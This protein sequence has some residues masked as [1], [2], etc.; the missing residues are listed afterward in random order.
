MESA[1]SLEGFDGGGLMVPGVTWNG[2]TTTN[3]TVTKMRL[4]R[5]DGAKWAQFGGVVDGAEYLK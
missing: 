1:R 3:A 2:S 5:W 4:A